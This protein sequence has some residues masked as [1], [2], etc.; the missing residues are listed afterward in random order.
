VLRLAA[1][2]LT[3]LLLATFGCGRSNLNLD[4]APIPEP[5][6]PAGTPQLFEVRMQPQASIELPRTVSNIDALRTLPGVPAAKTGS[7][8]DRWVILGRE[9]ETDLPQRNAFTPTQTTDVV[10]APFNDGPLGEAAYAIYRAGLRTFTAEPTIGLRWAADGAPLDWDNFYI[11]LSDRERNA[12]RWFKGPADG[13][14]TLDS[15]GQYCDHRGELL[16][17]VM[18][19]GTDSAQL[20][21]LEFGASETRATGVQG[22]GG[23]DAE[24]L[25]LL[26]ATGSLPGAVDLSADCAPV[27]DQ[28]SWEACTAFAV[29]DG[30]YNYELGRLYGGFG[31]DLTQPGNRLSPKWLYVKSGVAGGWPPNGSQGRYTDN[32]L[33]VARAQ[34]VATEANAPYDLNYADNFDTNA[35]VDALILNIDSW[36]EVPCNSDAGIN[37]LKIILAQ[38]LKPLVLQANLDSSF[39]GY[40][41]GLVWDYQGPRATSHAMAVVGYDDLRQAFKVRNSW[42]SAWGDGGYLWVSYNTFRNGAAG[43]R[44]WTL[45]DDYLHGAV[46]RFC[47]GGA[48]QRPVSGLKAS[49]GTA[50]TIELTWQSLAGA[51]GYRV[52][53]DERDN[54]VAEL[55][56]EAE[57]WEDASLSDNFGHTYWVSALDGPL[58]TPDV[59]FRA[60]AP[61]VQGV[62]LTEGTEGD[63]L[64]FSA[65]GT[66]SGN[67][68]YSW[69]FGGGA[70]P[71]TST[72][73]RPQV[74][75]S[76]PGVY[77]AHVKVLN[78][79]GLTTYNFTLTV[80]GIKPRI[81][82]ILRNSGYS[83]DSFALAADVQTSA[84]A[85]YSWELQ[86]ALPAT[87]NA[88]T[89][90]ITL[91][92]AGRYP[93][94]LTVTSPYGQDVR[95]FELMVLSTADKVW[96]QSGADVRLSR[97]LPVDGPA[98]NNVRWRYFAGVNPANPTLLSSEI[99]F[100]SLG[101]LYY[102][103]QDGVTCLDATGA[104]AWH[105]ATTTQVQYLTTT[106]EGYVLC[107]AQ[108]LQALKANGTHHWRHA[109][110]SINTRLSQPYVI[111]GQVHYLTNDGL[112]H[113]VGLVD[114]AIVSG[115]HFT[116]LPA[117]LSPQTVLTND[118]LI[119]GTDAVTLFAVD[120]VA[121]APRWIQ[122][123]GDG[124]LDPGVTLSPDQRS[125]YCANLSGHIH[126][127]DA[128]AGNQIFLST[129]TARGA[130]SY[131]APQATA[132][133]ALHVLGAS[134][135]RFRLDP[136]SGAVQSQLD[137]P[138]GAESR[139]L[140]AC[141]R[142]GNVYMAAYD[143]PTLYSYT[144]G[145][146]LRW[147]LTLSAP[148]AQP[149]SLGPDGTLYVGTQDGYIYAIGSGGSGQV[150]RPPRLTAITPDFGISDSEVTFSTVEDGGTTASYEWNFGLAAIPQE[151]TGATPQVTLNQPGLY[152]VH[153]TARNAW[154]E[155]KFEDQL[156]VSYP[157]LDWQRYTLSAD[158][159]L[160]VSRPALVSG[161]PA[162]A[163]NSNGSGISYLAQATTA[164]PAAAGDWVVT[165]LDDGSV[166]AHP[167]DLREW[168][169]RI[170]VAR[171][172]QDQLEVGL[173]T[174]LTPTGTAD[175]SYH[176]VHGTAG[177]GA[178]ARF[179]E[180]AD[181][182][183]VA[184]RDSL[185]PANLRFSYAQADL[186]AVSSDWLS[187]L[188]FDGAEW[189]GLAYQE[190]RPYVLCREPTLERSVCW[191]AN[192]AQPVHESDWRNHPVWFGELEQ[193]YDGIGF[194]LQTLGGLLGGAVLGQTNG[195]DVSLRFVQ[196]TTAHPEANSDWVNTVVDV[197]KAGLTPPRLAIVS[198]RP[199]VAYAVALHNTLRLAVATV[200][201]PLL[202]EQWEHYEI[203]T[204]PDSGSFIELLGYG[205]NV[206]IAY[207]QPETG[208]LSVAVAGL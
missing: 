45:N 205:D 196:A 125:I 152:D 166:L 116:Q 29:A 154:G 55:G 23:I 108:G 207:R 38:Q 148:A 62:N 107:S 138:L 174:D 69:N 200:P 193:I 12:W 74:T 1:L 66:G 59:G 187:Y 191:A 53:R 76:Q 180:V 176:N 140:Q 133:G 51:G 147:Q 202:Q 208:K 119:V 168:E 68:S 14:L 203:D 171:Q 153:I 197:S 50:T 90:V 141:D 150:R 181:R 131:P 142:H 182:L 22:L 82:R 71:N 198:G 80:T 6:A 123:M 99:V 145:G 160:G 190:N 39:F 84:G 37:T 157:E 173:S 9:Y 35:Q 144:P 156:W 134:F 63:T 49:D 114:G 78:G 42:S 83:G 70:V 158:A 117:T 31:W 13:V 19:L 100:D 192:I 17:C 109:P 170:A 93:C 155:H 72:L 44:T 3:L 61:E 120:P 136:W 98:T 137:P 36:A 48:G 106:A 169:G 73:P 92:Q 149:P 27:N 94:K 46:Q 25:P 199:V 56:P 195:D 101:R 60:S 135:V 4:G 88:I 26:G 24:Q 163:F 57:G 159:V 81:L 164:R 95:R 64:E 127:L 67:L 104:Y 11:G 15:F 96:R 43:V 41:P 139:G 177:A 97:Q 130:T 122:F 18:L 151:V 146:Q 65:V 128:A 10:L 129:A 79:L 86:G 103:T 126:A 77:P 121:R 167:Q 179:F 2:L 188:Q 21:Y 183:A 161:K 112:V 110:Q 178:K 47:P 132:D 16:V 204:A 172:K 34:G 54:L 8:I 52:Y 30:V 194:D 20:S 58:S 124:P 105:Y 28:G 189:F 165:P 186:P 33:D 75:L 5:A 143:N 87:S 91:G 102:G 115:G 162:I 175:W 85:Q 113:T 32:V 7:E 118:G 185:A 89:P 184:H 201:A 40:Q 206:L 111:D